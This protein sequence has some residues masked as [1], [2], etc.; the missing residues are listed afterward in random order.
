VPQ[1]N[2]APRDIKIEVIRIKKEALEFRLDNIGHKV[3][4]PLMPKIAERYEVNNDFSPAK[5]FGEATKK[6]LLPF[7]PSN[8]LYDGLVRSLLE[9]RENTGE[10]Q[11]RYEA[12]EILWG[13]GLRAAQF[14]ADLDISKGFSPFFLPAVPSNIMIEKEIVVNPATIHQ[15]KTRSKE[16]LKRGKGQAENQLIIK[17]AES[18]ELKTFGLEGLRRP[19]LLIEELYTITLPQDPTIEVDNISHFL[20][21]K[22]EQDT[23]QILL[24]K[25]GQEFHSHAFAGG[26][27]YR[28][29]KSTHPYFTVPETT[30]FPPLREVKN[31][32]PVTNDEIASLLVLLIEGIKIS[33]R[34]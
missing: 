27:W 10:S 2:R 24:L 32:T 8:E 28:I 33:R 1:G 29:D 3:Y 11:E 23:L 4:N 13:L 9:N 15:I 16:R 7:L 26:R 5:S 17:S 14:G 22:D 25:M 12:L 19:V 20:L 31:P 30:Q 18:E 6:I 34:Y 21:Y